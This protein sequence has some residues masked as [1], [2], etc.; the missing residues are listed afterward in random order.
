VTKPKLLIVEDEKPILQGLI[1][2]FVFHGYDVESAQD[3]TLGLERAVYSNFDLVILDV[4]LPGTDGFTICHELKKRKPAQPVILLTAKTSEEDVVTGLSLGADDYVGKPFSIRELTLRA[5]AVL[6]RSGKFSDDILEL[7]IGNFIRIDTRN[8][9]GVFTSKPD[10]ESISFTRKEIELLLYLH[11]HS[12]RPVTREELLCEVWGY[13]RAE[14]IETRTV[15]IHVAKLR[16][17]IELDPKVPIHL[18]TVR[19]GGYRLDGSHQ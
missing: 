8:M 17:K 11:R 3:G 5:Q 13:T 7:R 2:V 9:V 12:D 15:D 6:R 18:V 19:G 10:N 1:D 14:N 16:R 4:M